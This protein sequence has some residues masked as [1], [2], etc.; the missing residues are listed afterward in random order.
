MPYARARYYLTPPSV[1]I[2][3]ISLVLAVMAFMIRYAGINIPIINATRVFD[4][5]AIAYIVLL[6]GVLARRL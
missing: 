1:A 5:L 2:F 4:V 3:A 6:L